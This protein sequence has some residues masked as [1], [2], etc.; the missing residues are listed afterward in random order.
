MM[1]AADKSFR[2][3]IKHFNS[4]RNVDFAFY[5]HFRFTHKKLSKFHRRTLEICIQVFKDRW[6]IDCGNFTTFYYDEI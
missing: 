4:Y 6:Q 3:V 2:T 1:C 5:L